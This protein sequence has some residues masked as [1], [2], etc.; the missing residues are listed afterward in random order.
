M[1]LNRDNPIV[2]TRAGA[3]GAAADPIDA[4]FDA[5]A[6]EATAA[7]L[8][9][10]LRAD[11]R[12]AGDFV[13]TQRMVSMLKEPIEGPDL[14]DEILR[15]LDQQRAFRSR[16]RRPLTGRL[17]AGIGIVLGAAALWAI[18]RYAPRVQHAAPAPV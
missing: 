4:F 12:T 14:T 8:A 16:L 17:A 1:T 3:G 15:R 13:R 6:D 9:G 7:R 10:A 18:D 11:V 5:R 2:E